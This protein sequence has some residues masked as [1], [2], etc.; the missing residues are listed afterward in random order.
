MRIAETDYREFLT[1]WVLWLEE[2]QIV[3]TAA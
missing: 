1:R 2:A 3:K